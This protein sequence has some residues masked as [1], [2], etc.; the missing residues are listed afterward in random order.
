ESMKPNLSRE[1]VDAIL[2]HAVDF[3]EATAPAYGEDR[4]QV[5]ARE[6]WE[7]LEA[8]ILA[9]H[10]PQ[11]EGISLA[12]RATH[13]WRMQ[14]VRD[15]HAAGADDD[16][17]GWTESAGDYRGLVMLLE[18][19]VREIEQARADLLDLTAP[20]QAKHGN[21]RERQARA[22]GGAAEAA[23]ARA[24]RAEERCRSARLDQAGR[25]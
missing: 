21:A 13:L 18:V 9:G 23:R 4:V 6:G 24:L 19:C 2:P 7:W 25:R 16:A 8:A 22:D 20:A 14:E 17:L 3:S 10:L 12:V 15:A 1:I 11:L 5:V